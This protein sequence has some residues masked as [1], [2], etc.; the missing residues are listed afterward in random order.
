M[1]APSKTPRNIVNL[2]SKEIAQTL[3]RADIQ[4]GIANQ[5]AIAKYGT[6]EA[7]DKLVHE[8]IATRRKVWK[9]AGVRVE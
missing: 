9:A 4:Q 3:A 6:A 1:L 2:L 7:F 5:G 8:E